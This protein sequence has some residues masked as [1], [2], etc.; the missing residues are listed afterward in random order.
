MR[1]FQEVFRRCRAEGILEEVFAYTEHMFGEHQF[2]PR[3]QDSLQN[4]FR[5]IRIVCKIFSWAGGKTEH[6]FPI[7]LAQETV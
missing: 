2:G 3:N 6:T 7:D 5:A 4:F 1:G